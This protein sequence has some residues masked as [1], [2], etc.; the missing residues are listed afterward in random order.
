MTYRAVLHGTA[1]TTSSQLI[2]HIEQW[3]AEAGATITIQRILLEVDGSCTVAVSSLTDGE[4]QL[5]NADLTTSSS[6]IGAIIGG[7]VVAVV[8]LLLIF[9]ISVVTVCLVKKRQIKAKP[10]QP[11]DGKRYV[12][13]MYIV[14]MHD[15]IMSTIIAGYLNI[16]LSSQ[17]LTLLMRFLTIWTMNMKAWINTANHKSMRCFNHQLPQQSNLDQLVSL[18]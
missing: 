7:V 3:T 2:S 11:N 8:I 12:I 6:N 15:Y 9:A 13:T 5:R 1:S 18:S 4:C 17:L 10:S 14:G 16:R